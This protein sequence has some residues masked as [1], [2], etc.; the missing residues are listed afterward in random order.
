MPRV[1]SKIKASPEAVQIWFDGNLEPAFSKMEVYDESHR[2]VDEGSSRV[3][4]SDAVLLEDGLPPLPPGRY[5][6]VWR[7][8]AVDGHRTEGDFW[9]T[10][11]G[12][13]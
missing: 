3:D 10:V 8:V 4:P 6:V 13:S 11:E 2:R 9:F 7:V 5:Q 12:S 1:G